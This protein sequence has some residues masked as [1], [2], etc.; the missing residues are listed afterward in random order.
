MKFTFFFLQQATFGWHN[1]FSSYQPSYYQAPRWYTSGYTLGSSSQ[2]SIL[3]ELRRKTSDSYVYHASKWRAIPIAYDNIGN[4]AGNT[5]NDN[6]MDS[7]Y[8]SAKEELV[9][10]L[11]RAL[12]WSANSWIL[13]N[14]FFFLENKE[15]SCTNLWCQCQLHI[16][17]HKRARREG[18]EVCYKPQFPEF[19]R[20]HKNRRTQRSKCFFTSH[21]NRAWILLNKTKV[22]SWLFITLKPEKGDVAAKDW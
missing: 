5:F 16:S 11:F 14:S 8:N 10:L 20:E 22:N 12:V 1:L 15:S 17:G 3:K 9:F 21:K 19:G 4:Q 13:K 2:E 6:L 7:I 18:Q